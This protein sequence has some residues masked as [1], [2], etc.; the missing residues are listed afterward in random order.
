MS[1]PDAG[2]PFSAQSAGPDRRR[3]PAGSRGVERNHD[4]PGP[5]TP[6]EAMTHASAI[7]QFRHDQVPMLELHDD[8]E[9]RG[10]LDLIRIGRGATHYRSSKGTIGMVV[11]ERCRLKASHP[12]RRPHGDAGRA[13][14]RLRHDR[15]SRDG[16]STG[17]CIAARPII[18]AARN[19]RESSVADPEQYLGPPAAKSPVAASDARRA[20]DLPD[21][22]RDRARRAGR[23]SEMRNGPGAGMRSRRRYGQSGADRHDAALLDRARVGAAIVSARDGGRSARRADFARMCHRQALSGCNSRWRRRWCSGRA[24]RFSRAAGNRWRTAASTCSR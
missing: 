7:Q 12:R 5:A 11:H 17:T 1:C 6:R 3:L 22:S 15:R 8:P 9:A 20:L 24:R 2:P 21:A 10:G 18:S 13:G 14:P 16:Q 23:L 19:C 4:W